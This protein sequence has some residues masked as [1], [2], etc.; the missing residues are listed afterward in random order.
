MIV[1]VNM[2]RMNKVKWI[3]KGNKMACVEC[4]IRGEHLER[5]LKA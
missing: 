1:S 5:D 3:D 4:G 2:S